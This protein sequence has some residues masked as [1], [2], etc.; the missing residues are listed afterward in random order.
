MWDQLLVRAVLI[1]LI[2]VVTS[3]PSARKA[4]AAA[5]VMSAPATAYSTMVRPASSA[6]TDASGVNFSTRFSIV[7]SPCS[8]PRQSGRYGPRR[9]ER[10]QQGGSPRLMIPLG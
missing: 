8:P 2:L 5:A 6:S 1:A 7:D 4:A 9:Y 3:P 10:A